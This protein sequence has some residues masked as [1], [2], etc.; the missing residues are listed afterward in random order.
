MFLFIFL[1]W[2]T[3]FG[4]YHGISPRTLSLPH[5]KR[6]SLDSRILQLTRMELTNNY[7]LGSSTQTAADLAHPRP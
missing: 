2:H 6:L 5:L 1:G 7:L 4:F 3:W